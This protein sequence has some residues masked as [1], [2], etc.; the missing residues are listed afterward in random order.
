MFRNL[1]ENSLS[2]ASDPVRIEIHCREADD[3]GRTSSLHIAVRD[4][5]PGLNQEQRCKVFDA[6]YTTKTKGIGLGM[7]IVKRIVE[8]HGGRIALGD[9]CR[10]GAEFQIMLP[11]TIS[12][13]SV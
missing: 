5:G 11:R 9:E 6:F 12:S 7:A 3:G 8:A 13:R 4:N 1:F 2:A 10:E